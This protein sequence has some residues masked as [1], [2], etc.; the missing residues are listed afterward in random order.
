[1]SALRR[2]PQDAGI[3]SMNVPARPRRDARDSPPMRTFA[4]AD[5][6]SRSG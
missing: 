5:A 6:R 3:T 2:E 4:L 1:M